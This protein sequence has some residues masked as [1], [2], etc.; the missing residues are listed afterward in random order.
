MQTLF[1][2]TDSTSLCVTDRQTDRQ[3]DT[4]TDSQNSHT[5]VCSAAVKMLMTEK[6]KSQVFA[7]FYGK[8]KS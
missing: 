2:Y 1:R 7:I 8:L 3:T 6:H 4:Q 5:A